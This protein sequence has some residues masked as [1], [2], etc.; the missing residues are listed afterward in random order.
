VNARL[1]AITAAKHGICRRKWGRSIEYCAAGAGIA[2]G[3]E[4]IT[5]LHLFLEASA[6]VSKPIDPG[7]LRYMT[8]EHLQPGSKAVEAA[9]TQRTKRSSRFISPASRRHCRPSGHRP[10]A[11]NSSCRG[12]PPMRTRE[13][14]KPAS[15][16]PSANIA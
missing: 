14:P 15:R 12:R 3:D 9:I 8:S 1:A 16:F 7:S 11:Q 2:R 6:P 13:L 10:K 4:G 5:A